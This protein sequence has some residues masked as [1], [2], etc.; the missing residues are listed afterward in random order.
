MRI[1]ATYGE[2]FRLDGRCSSVAKTDSES[3]RVKSTCE[4]CAVAFC[5]LSTTLGVLFFLEGGASAAV[6]TN[7]DDA[8][9]F[10]DD[11]V[12]GLA[13]LLALVKE[14]RSNRVDVNRI[15]CSDNCVFCDL[16]TDD[17]ADSISFISSLSFLS[18]TF[19]QS[20]VKMSRFNFS[21]RPN[22]W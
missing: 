4:L 20:F 7:A 17:V 2:R 8:N 10:A 13:M 15:R 9:R 6:A 18:M 12:F 3:S 5:L 16:A 21:P 22:L 1:S 11:R 19:S 14:V